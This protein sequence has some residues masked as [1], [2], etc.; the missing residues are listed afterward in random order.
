MLANATIARIRRTPGGTD[1]YGDPIEGTESRA[2]MEDWAVAPRSSSDITDRG[3]A[4]VIV[5]YTLYT[6]HDADF[7]HTDL[8][9]VDG[10]LYEIEGVVGHWKS[11]LSTWAAGTETALRR[12]AG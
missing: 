11:P 2:V 8:V 10:D 1:D 4:G 12:A 5:G 7:V 6:P 3:R 9:E